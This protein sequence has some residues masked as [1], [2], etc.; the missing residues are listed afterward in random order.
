M[1]DKSLFL[2]PTKH[3]VYLFCCMFLSLKMKLQSIYAFVSIF[4]VK[5]TAYIQSHKA[6]CGFILYFLSYN[7]LF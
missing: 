7:T 1:H 5:A 2:S 3:S 6:L 4:F